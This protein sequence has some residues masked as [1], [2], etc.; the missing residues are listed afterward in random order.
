MAQLGRFKLPRV[1]N[2]PLRTYGVN[3]DERHM[4]QQALK[5][6]KSAI[7]QHGPF[8]VP[9]IVNGI[10][11]QT[12][13]AQPQI[14]PQDHS[15]TLCIY[16]QADADTITKAIQTALSA[17]P[18]WES[19]PFNDRAAIFLK[20]ADLLA[21][22]YRYKVMA[23]TMLGQGK[24]AWQAEI[25]AAA[26]LID[27]W[28]FN[29]VYAA[30]IYANQP[31]ENSPFTWNRLEYR[32]LE[33]FVL[34]ISPFNFTAIGGNLA[35]APALM[36]NV[37][38]W[39]PSPMAVYSNYL[40]FQILMEAGLPAGVIQF[41]PGDA[42]AIADQALS[43]PEFAG[44]HFTGST[45]VF[46]HLWQKIASNLNIYKSYPRIVG[47]TGGKNMH[48]IHKSADASSAA[49]QTVRSAF[50]YSGQKCSACS[51]AYVPDSMWD[52]FSHVLLAEIKKIKQGPIDDFSTFMGPVIN[53]ASFDKIKKYV[54]LVAID[55]SSTLIAGGISD[56][57]KGYFIQPTVILTTNPQSATMVAELFG[58]VLTIYVY[59]ADAYEQTLEIADK[60]SPYGLTAALFAQDRNAVILGAEKL[61]QS[62]GN[63]YIN[64]KS[65]GAVV[66][67]QPFGG[68][69]QSGTND[70][71]GSGLNLQRWVSAR[72]IKETFVPLTA[73]AYPSN[74][75]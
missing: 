13:A 58:P 25:D 34:A 4:L 31:T 14:L 66:G 45:T 2:E 18:A 54:E 57:S 3:S 8:Q 70:K 6:M 12:N 67:Q 50:E 48:F 35:G 62:A 69:R 36:G 43:H 39:K 72:A 17:K 24:N 41:I 47:E 10:K 28:R 51:R 74:H 5:D 52:E 68:S 40:V 11:I 44:L 65:T 56:D 22:K 42:A 55:A 7:H 1:S 33:G 26:E 63:F 38:L 29:C 53:K 73:A 20:A 15:T 27:F 23:A 9:C 37:V 46:K 64:D 32:A 19:M 21:T 59:P 49:M 75:A 16:H 60:T 61:R 30:D 71:A